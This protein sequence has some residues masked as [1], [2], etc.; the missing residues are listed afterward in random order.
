MSF[1]L[2]AAMLIG[3]KASGAAVGW[4][5]QFQW[6]WFIAGDGGADHVVRG[7][8]LGMAADRPAPPRLRCGGQRQDRRPYADAFLTGAFATLLATPCSAPFVGTAIGF[9]LARGPREIAIVF[10]AMGLG[11]AAPYLAVAAFPRLV[12]LLPRPGHWMIRL[13]ACSRAGAGRY[14]GVAAVRAGSTVGCH[15]SRSGPAIALLI[16]LLCCC[17]KSRRGVPAA[18]A[19]LASAGAA[20]VVAVAVVWPAFAGVDRPVPA[21]AAGPW[22]PFD[23]AEIHRLVGEGKTV[24]VDVTAAW[25]LTCKVNEAAVLDREPV[26]GRLFGAGVVAMRGDWTRPDPALA[27]ICRASAATAS[28]SMRSTGRAGREAR[29]CP[30]CLTTEAVRGAS[31]APRAPRALPGTGDE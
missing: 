18:L 22:R 20:A 28:R 19:R 8:P 12:R 5:I 17:L 13:C 23:P 30:S 21:R 4:G 7:E 27:A 1:A 14:R 3:L 25:C 26:A 10:L 9:A 16:V 24:F 6:P 15:G 29:R 11:F 2:I 31:T